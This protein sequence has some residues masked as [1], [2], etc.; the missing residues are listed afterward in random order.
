MIQYKLTGTTTIL[1]ITI[2][3]A[4]L[5]TKTITGLTNGVSYDFQVRAFGSSAGSWSSVVSQTPAVP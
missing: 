5:T 2:V 4:D 1:S 3:P